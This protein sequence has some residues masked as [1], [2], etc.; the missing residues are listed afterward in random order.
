MQSNKP[1]LFRIR[2]LALVLFLFGGIQ[3]PLLSTTFESGIDSTQIFKKRKRMVLGTEIGIGVGVHTALYFA[4]Y[5]TYP[6]GK[7]HF[8]DDGKEWMQMD[9]MG[10]AFSAY[11]LGVMGYEAGLWAGYNNKQAAMN[12]LL[13]GTGF[14]TMIEVFDGFSQKWGASVSDIAANSVGSLAFYAQARTWGEQ[15]ITMKY[16]FRRT[17]YAPLR[18]NTLGKGLQQEF[19]KD[20]NGQSYWLSFNLAGLT[21]IESKYLPDWFCLSLGYGAN[22]MLGG[23]RNIWEDSRS[24]HIYDYSHIPRY[25][26]YY[27]SA[28]IDWVKMF[29][30]KK[31]GVKLLLTALNCIKVPFPT[32]EYNTLDKGFYGRWVR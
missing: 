26:E 21:G 16:S 19:L 15:K 7:F 12:G 10:H 28:D 32:L 8:M 9:K 11:Y 24:S 17:E 23:Y 20:Y 30:P 14:Q 25:R 5:S 3:T 22:G 13:L 29:K 2:H 27:L 4:W 6:M 1:Y 18:P 31:R